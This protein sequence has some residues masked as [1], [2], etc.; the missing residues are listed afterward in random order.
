MMGRIFAALMLLLFANVAFGQITYSP[1][2]LA[3][4]QIAIGGDAGG[5]NYVTLI[6]IVNN[7]STSTNGHIALFSDSGSA[8][9]AQFDGQSPQSTL[10]VTLASGATRQIQVTTTGA[11]TAGWMQITYTPSDALTTVLLQFRSGTTLLSEVGV[12]PAFDTLAATDFAAETDAGLNTGIALAN[13]ST[14]AGFV[15]ARLWDPSTGNQTTGQVIT[16]PANGHVSKL[17]TELFPSVLNISQIR[18]KVSFDS[19]SSSSCNFAGGNGFLGT[20]IRLNGDQFTTIPVADR[21]MD[22]NQVRVLPQVAFGG[23]ANGLNMRTVLYLTTNVSTGVFGTADIFDNDG[24]PLAASADGAAPASSI[25]IT[26]AGNQ[27]KRIVL[28]GDATLRSGWIR[29]TLSG[30]VHLIAN[31]VFQTFNGSTLA[32]EASVLDSDSIN[33]GLIYVKV[34]AGDANVGVAFANAQSSPN[35]ITLSLFNSAGIA[36][37]TRTVTLPANG[38]LAQFV[39]EIFPELA[40]LTDFDGALSINS[41]TSFSALALRLTADK[42]ATLPVANNGMY[43]PSI[44]GL[45]VTRT[46]RTVPAQLNFEIDVKD[47]DKDLATSSSTSVSG[48]GFIDFGSSGYD[49]GP[50]TLNGANLIGK[51]SGT[52]SGTFQPPNVTGAIPSGF[53]AVFYIYVYDAAGNESNFVSIPVRF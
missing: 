47:F 12:D 14:T 42:I 4:P 18:A 19:C 53:S 41:A 8:L 43:R 23:P 2:S 3:F 9:S 36:A 25:A 28:S 22:G 33:R 31:A 52:L 17:L 34:H 46:Q 51:D 24:N 29:L 15:L 27:V 48:V 32:S 39:T 16:L 37:G 21:P 10:D 49:F 7:N 20:A 5:Q 11:I 13:P 44:I 38:H 30:T 35:D 26:V 40:S 6:Q 50:V 45:R 1:V